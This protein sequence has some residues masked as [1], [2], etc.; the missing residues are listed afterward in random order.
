MRLWRA[1]A[2]AAAR[3]VPGPTRRCRS[4]A[5]QPDTH[6]DGH[7]REDADCGCRA[8]ASTNRAAGLPPNMNHFAF[9]TTETVIQVSAEGPNPADDPSHSQ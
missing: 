7:V 5:R 8:P 2:M 6:G 9:A 4:P 3:R 1:R